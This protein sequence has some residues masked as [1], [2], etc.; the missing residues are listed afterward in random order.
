M[1]KKIASSPKRRQKRDNSVNQETEVEMT[2]DMQRRQSRCRGGDSPAGT[3]SGWVSR[4]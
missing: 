4:V 3:S 1:K 2:G